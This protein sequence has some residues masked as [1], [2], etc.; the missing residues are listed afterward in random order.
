MEFFQTTLKLMYVQSYTRKAS[1]HNFDKGRDLLADFYF[2]VRL[3]ALP[4][5][6]LINFV[7]FNCVSFKRLF[8]MRL[9]LGL[10]ARRANDF[11]SELEI[12]HLT[13]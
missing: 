3:L 7:S 2:V 6:F 12:N 4:G 10:F 1:K 8:L 9:D 5:L 11:D 13:I